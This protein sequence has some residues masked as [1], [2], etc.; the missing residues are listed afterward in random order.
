MGNTRSEEE[1]VCSICFDGG[2]DVHVVCGCRGGLQ[3]MHERCLTRWMALDHRKCD[4]CLQDYFKGPFHRK[5][6]QKQPPSFSATA[7]QAVT[8]TLELT[9]VFVAHSLVRYAMSHEFGE[10][11][12]SESLVFACI[13]CWTARAHKK[14]K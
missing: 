8:D 9:A 11:E 4:A 12:V 7:F 3:H 6:E 13:S 5:S 10:R 2:D 1:P 14:N